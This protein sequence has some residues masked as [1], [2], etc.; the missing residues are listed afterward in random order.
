MQVLNQLGVLHHQLGKHQLAAIYLQNALAA[1][2]AMAPGLPCSNRAGSSSSSSSGSSDHPSSSG[3][4]G[5]QQ[6]AL[7]TLQQRHGNSSSSKQGA[8]SGAHKQQ[9]GVSTTTSSGSSSS[10]SVQLDA[11]SGALAAD[12]TYD[13]LYNNG[14][15]QLLLGHW[16]QA[17]QCFSGAASKHYMQPQLW[18]RCAE[19]CIGLY[20][21]HQQQQLLMDQQQAAAAL[22]QHVAQVQQQQQQQA[23]A[24]QPQGKAHKRGQQQQG[25]AKSNQKAAAAKEA[26]AA[27]PAAGSREASPDAPGPATPGDQQHELL[28]HEHLL[29][30]LLEAETL[31]PLRALPAVMAAAR[32]VQ[33]GPWPAGVLAAASVDAGAGAGS[34]V[35]ADSSRSSTSSGG[36]GAAAATGPQGSSSCMQ[37]A[38]EALVHLNVAYA[39]LQDLQ[40]ESA[41]EAEAA[42]ALAAEAAAAIHCGLGIL[43]PGAAGGGAPLELQAGDSSSSGPQGRNSSSGGSSQSLTS[44]PV[45]Y[46][47]GGGS[48]STSAAASAAAAAARVASELSGAAEWLPV[49]HAIL[50]NLAY[51]HLLRQ[52]PLPALHAARSLLAC[53]ELSPDQ[54]F[55]GN[56]YAAEALCMLGRPGDAHEQLQGH[57]GLFAEGGD[58]CS[59]AIVLGSTAASSAKS[60]DGS[61]ATAEGLSGCVA[62]A[63][64]PAAMA[65]TGSAARAALL[66]NMG[67]V[68]AVQGDL[69]A[70]EAAGR[71]ALVCEPGSLH[72]LLLL[73]YLRL[74]RA[75][76]SIDQELDEP[77]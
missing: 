22:R 77:R 46:A 61:A 51:V 74:R 26:A 20:H 8:P 39:L 66:V 76:L 57:M 63:A 31:D 5:S 40:A 47:A 41:K 37:W 62:A 23:A 19:A 21:H 52:D 24:S 13:L 72:A 28:R 58:N 56:S 45:Q 60:D 11:W 32:V 12:Y 55:L 6:S 1:A 34:Q 36:G 54:H 73:V 69:D 50:S 59:S 30:E 64:G 4:S 44:A 3:G 33:A 49:Q 65:W 48:G 29:R 71:R 53:S 25:G 18:V 14:L 43:P 68:Q 75:C 16:Q 7:V 10:G 15:Q 70:A 67:T 2:Q 42:A 9:A 38:D 27:T 35:L 17:L